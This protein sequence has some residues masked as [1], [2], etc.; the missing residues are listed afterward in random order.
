[1]STA[2]TPERPEDGRDDDPQDRAPEHGEAPGH[3][4]DQRAEVKT[5]ADA[6]AA[7]E[8]DEAG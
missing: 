6:Q 1:M 4:Q 5:D 8:R 7:D 2:H 3:A